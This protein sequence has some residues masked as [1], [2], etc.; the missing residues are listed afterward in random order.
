MEVLATGN[1]ELTSYPL[2]SDLDNDVN[3]IIM[4]LI[5]LFKTIE[6]FKDK[7]INLYCSGSSGAIMAT[8]FSLHVKNCKIIHIKK[9]GEISHRASS[10]P[11]E[12]DKIDVIIDDFISTGATVDYIYSNM[13]KYVDCL[14]ISGTPRI[15]RIAFIPR[16]VIC[17]MDDLQLKEI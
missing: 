14:I 10:Y 4:P 2:G 11:F 9:L 1:P 8:I 16:Y 5:N 12:K 6:E 7:N 3:T 17:G 15:N 13:G